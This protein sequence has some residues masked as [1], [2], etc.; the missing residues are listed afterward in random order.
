[1]IGKMLQ[2][3]VL[4]VGLLGSSAAAKERFVV[5]GDLQDSSLA[6]RERDIVL[7]ERI[8]DIQPA[9]SVFVG[10]IKEGNS[11]CTD[12]LF[13]AMRHVFDQHLA[14]L[15]FTP[16]DNEWTDCWRKPAGG[17]DTA[18][19]KRA[20]VSKFTETH[21]S[22]GQKTIRLDQ[23]EGQPENARWRWNDVVFATLHITGSNNNFQQ[24]ADA[25]A[26][27]QQRDAL[28]A[29]W[30]D[31]AFVAAADAK[32]LFLFIHANPKWESP[33][34]EPTGFDRFRDQLAKRA[35]D[36]PG[37]IVLAHGDTHTFRIDKPFG[38]APHM[39][40]VEVFGPPQRGAVII[41]VNPESEELFRFAPLL[42]DP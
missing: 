5:F 35:A 17:F 18:E 24:R 25:I 19:R 10:D 1:M 13:D 16:G 12:E 20:V 22:I 32:G 7:I 30:L 29:I 27:H 6:G 2:V 34:W 3:A 11:P 38:S 31:E 8:N 33:W 36:I 23:Q 26:E 39:T 4:I 40:R 15:I 37:S 28:N 42:L 14:P 21:E 41:E 9:F